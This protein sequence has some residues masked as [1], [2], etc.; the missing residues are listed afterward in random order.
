MH[1][2][3]TFCGHLRLQK[4]TAAEKARKLMAMDNMAAVQIRRGNQFFLLRP[5][6]AANINYDQR[7]K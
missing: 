3:A 4:M 1:D 6:D 5:L 2:M 7:S